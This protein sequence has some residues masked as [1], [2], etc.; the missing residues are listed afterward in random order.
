[1]ILILLKLFQKFKEEIAPSTFYEANIILMPKP[2]KDNTE[3]GNCRPISY[4][5]TDAKVLNKILADQIQ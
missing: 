2:G 3:K 4:I 5:N 1:M